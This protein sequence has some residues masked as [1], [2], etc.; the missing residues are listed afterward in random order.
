MIPVLAREENGRKRSRLQSPDGCSFFLVAGGS[1]EG[2][3]NIIGHVKFEQV[4]SYDPMVWPSQEEIDHMANECFKRKRPSRSQAFHSP[5][6]FLK[7]SVVDT[8]AL[9]EPLPFTWGTLKTK[10]R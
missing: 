6:L 5:H 1:E 4:E 9:D 7:F 2:G 8:F 3:A 10:A